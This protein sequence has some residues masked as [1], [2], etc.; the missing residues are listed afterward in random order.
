MTQTPIKP[1][2]TTDI[3][4]KNSDNIS[5]KLREKPAKLIAKPLPKQY[6]KKSSSLASQLLQ[7]VLPT[8]LIPLVL[9]SFLGYRNVQENEE[10]RV[11]DLLLDEVLLIEG[12]ASIILNNSWQT[13]NILVQNPLVIQATRDAAIKVENEG[14]DQL[15]IGDLE[16][17]FAETKLLETNEVLNNYLKNITE[18]TDFIEVFITDKNGFNI[19]YSNPTSDFVQSDEDWWKKANNEAQYFQLGD[20]DESSQSF[21][22]EFYKK[23]TDP[24]TGEFLG[25]LKAILPTAKFN[26]IN[27]LLEHIAIKGT[28]TLQLIDIFS[29]TAFD[30]VTSEG[31]V[32]SQ[33]NDIVGGKVILEIASSLVEAIENPGVDLTD[34]ASTWEGKY[35]VTLK[36]EPFEHKND[37]IVLIARVNYQGV[38]YA[39]ATIPNTKW[40]AVSSIQESEIQQA[41]T[42]LIQVF[43]LIGV[44][45]GV[46]ATGVVLLLSKRLS[47]P[48]KDL[49][50][51]AN[52]IVEGNLNVVAQAE[53]TTETE[54]LAETFNNLISKVTELLEQQEKT[55][56][57][58]RLLAEIT[59]IRDLDEKTLNESF[60]AMLAKIRQIWPVDRLVIYRF[61]PN[62]NGYISSE[63]V[64]ENWVSALTT[65]FRDPCIP[66]EL[67][68]AYKNGR[69]LANENVFE[70]EFHPEH[71][72]L[73]DRL[74]VKANL[75]VPIIHEGEL[76]G[77][78]IAH[79]CAHTHV[80]QEAEIDFLEK[81]GLQFGSTINQ[82]NKFKKELL[83]QQEQRREKE[84]LQ[85]RALELL[86]EVD[87]LSQGD[88]TIRATVTSDEIGTI[89]DSYNATIESLRKIVAQVKKASL[90]VSMT[91]S[92]NES[93]VQNL[94]S[95][96]QR[97]AEEITKTQQLIQNMDQSL[98]KIALNANKAETAV[99]QATLTIKSG[100]EAMDRTVEGILTVRNT[101]QETVNKVRKL[102]QASEKIAEVVSLITRFAAQTHLLALKASIEAARAGEEGV[103]F[104]VIADEVRELATQSSQAT[105][106]IEQIVNEIQTETSQV[107]TAMETGT[108]QVEQSTL[109]VA[110]TRR[111][112]NLIN[113]A[114]QAINQLV[115]EIAESTNTQGQDSK[116]VNQ[117]MANIASISQ[118][119]STTAVNFSQSFNQLLTVAQELLESVAKFKVY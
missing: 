35:P 66:P 99:Q 17:Q 68:A 14:L 25:V 21:G 12:A 44:I 109:L 73:M 65:S 15:T 111:N 79:Y 92:T 97:Q 80:W 104:A 103:G 1:E 86:M 33:D 72:A 39:M 114:T 102:G 4:Q 84:E 117:N 81:L 100:D 19:A 82:I 64:A 24:Q 3:S 106:Q 110:E 22:L 67:I 88:L 11:T 36:I 46:V 62:F 58:T 7:T 16:K 41:G 49:A 34:L 115:T 29:K 13:P 89:A 10:N 37:K 78:L 87:S 56:Q 90:E 5:V 98:S 57:K 94:A 77:L 2:N 96:A 59:E 83:A 50:D 93:L 23:I 55:T 9:A 107:V 116:V 26:I 18:N 85:R 20:F 113:E 91:T 60:S 40:V 101:V 43:S 118:T 51:T 119:T 45:L 76:F 70:T 38:Q 42:D 95:E 8:V 71:L 61:Q 30:T 27:D 105:A 75:I 112:L 47:Q 74:Q 31:A 63:S 69:V 108:E 6:E 28:Q 53:G 54:T 52:L 48:L 32:T